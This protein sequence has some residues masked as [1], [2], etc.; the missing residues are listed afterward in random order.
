[1]DLDE[2]RG[3]A[4]QRFPG[5]EGGANRSYFGAPCRLGHRRCR[6]KRRKPAQCFLSD[7]VK[8]GTRK[9]PQIGVRLQQSRWGRADSLP[10]RR[11][12]NIHVQQ[13][14]SA[15]S[16]I[17]CLF[18]GTIIVVR[19]QLSRKFPKSAIA[20]ETS[21]GDKLQ[22]S[23]QRDVRIPSSPVFPSNLLNLRL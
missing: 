15:G 13:I 17:L 22:A 3:P 21:Q 2:L 20:E 12:L 16:R 7:G 10:S 14:S 8:S 18:P 1:M 6:D 19:R 4:R 5:V 23:L 9:I 11:P